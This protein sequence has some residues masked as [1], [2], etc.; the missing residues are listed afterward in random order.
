MSLLIIG[1]SGTVG[2]Q[3]LQRLAARGVAASALVRTAGKSPLPASVT[4]VIG[5]MTDVASMRAALS[6]VRTLYLLNAVVADE[7]TQALITLNLAREAGITRVVYQSVIHADRWTNVPHFA[8]KY[9]VERMIFE[10]GIP[11]SVLRPAYFMQNDMRMRSVIEGYGAYPMPI[12]SAGV[13]MVDV[14]DIADV[15]VAELLARHEAADALPSRTLDVV[16]PEAMTA[17]SA[18]GTWSEALGREIRVGSGDLTAFDQQMAAHGPS[19]MAYDLR[20]MMDRAQQE[21]MHP[22]PGAISALETLLGRPLRR[23]AELVRE[24]TGANQ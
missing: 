16:G 23:Y 8:G 24:V 9:A 13:H 19:W 11:V 22:E 12:G 2:T 5:D 15:A 6:G 10:E 20:V 3:I 21:G 7:V 18:A 1:A 4:E 14:R 17:A